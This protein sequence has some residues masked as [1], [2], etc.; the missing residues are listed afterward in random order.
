M[1]S[2]NA[3]GFQASEAP[4]K[5]AMLLDPIYYAT[6]LETIIVECKRSNVLFLDDEPRRQR[7]PTTKYCYESTEL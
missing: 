4:V 2:L 7:S 5:I 3:L 6:T 1:A